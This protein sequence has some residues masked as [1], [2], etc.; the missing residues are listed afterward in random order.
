MGS[1]SDDVGQQTGN[2]TISVTV[3]YA[4]TTSTTVLPA[5]IVITS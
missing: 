3:G 4:A 2:G 5:P 1:V